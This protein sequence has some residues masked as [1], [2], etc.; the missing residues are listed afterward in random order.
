MITIFIN[1]VEVTMPRQARI[2]LNGLAGAYLELIF[3][4]MYWPGGIEIEIDAR[5]A[6][7]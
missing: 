2:Q 4:P 3:G 5:S 6:G 7:A 1:G